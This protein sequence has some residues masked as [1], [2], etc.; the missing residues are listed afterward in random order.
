[1]GELMPIDRWSMQRRRGEVAGEVEE[2]SIELQL[3]GSRQARQ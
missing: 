3:D 1:M 2:E